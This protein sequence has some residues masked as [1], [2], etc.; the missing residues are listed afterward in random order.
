MT[1]PYRYISADS[2]LEIDSKHWISRVPAKYRELA[3]RLVRQAD[4]S[5]IWMI[6][7]KIKR[8]AAAADLYGGKGRDHYVPFGGCYE[9]TPGT[10]SAE[11]RLGEQNQDGLDAEVL[12][13]SQQGGPKFWRRI[14]DHNAYKA[15][16]RAYNSWLAEEYCSVDP[17]RLLGVGI[18]PLGCSLDDT[19]AE[20]DYCSRAGFKTVL[21]QGFPSG[22]SY[23]SVEDDVFWARALEL[24][25][26]VSVHVDLDRT[27]E[28]KGPLFKYP[29]EPE[30]V[31][32][33]IT[34]DL[35]DQ[36]GRFGPVRGN[37]SVAAVQWVLAGLF[38]RFPSLRIFFAENQIGWIP[39]FLQAADVRY[40]RHHR[41]A[42]RLLGL[43]PLRRPPSEYLREHFYWGFQFDRVGVELRHKI[44]I[45][46][47]MWG[48]DFPHQESDWPESLKIIDKNF[49]GVP[50]DEREKMVC[51]NA[52]EFFRLS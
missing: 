48:S 36:V 5:D 39:F 25:M 3:P 15:V 4:G 46:R 21:L 38:D 18:L 6:S 24:N 19:L 37:G 9:G 13:P 28:R 33:K 41:W 27:G 40:D 45:D 14:A 47:L 50:D 51:A 12:F 29:R 49:S 42:E 8:A 26:P 17:E 7:D 31:M 1:R 35:V 43:K 32:K 22:K 20:L 16:L 52:V 2:H 23:P 44:N 30:E 34:H 11:Q 10:G